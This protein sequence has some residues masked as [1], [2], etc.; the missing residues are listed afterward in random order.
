[1]MKMLGSINRAVFRESSLR[2]HMSKE[3][4]IFQEVT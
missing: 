1:M 3:L 2:P 4:P